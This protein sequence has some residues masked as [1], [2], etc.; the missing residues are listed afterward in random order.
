MK[1][2]V[3]ASVTALNVKG[4]SLTIPTAVKGRYLDIYSSEEK[5]TLT[6]RSQAIPTAVKGRY[7]DICSSEEKGTLT[8]RSQLIPTAVKGKMP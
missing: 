1:H 4:P 2:H 8:V 3:L 6:V 7:P 5:G